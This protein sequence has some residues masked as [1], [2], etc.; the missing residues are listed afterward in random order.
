MSGAILEVFDASLQKTQVWLNDLMAELGWES[1][2]QKA[3]LALRTALHALRDRLTVEEAV[4]L[5]AQLPI[6][7]R[8]VYYEGWKLT[9]KPVK[10]RHKS[11]FLNHIAAAFR[12]DATVDPEKVMRAV[13]KVLARHISKGEIENVKHML[14]KSLQELWP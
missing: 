13:F 3:C 7:V 9:G 2:P 11:D 14:P 10:E 4:H 8:G 6:L 1:R 12:D 5:G